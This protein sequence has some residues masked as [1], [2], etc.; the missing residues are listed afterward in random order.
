MGKKKKTIKV[1]LDTNVLL[2]ALLFKG[3]VPGIAR[4]WKK[5]KFTPVIS[6][7]TFKE[8]RSV[9]EYPKFSLSKKEIAVI[10]TR[11]ILPY[12][13]VVEVGTPVKGICKDPDD[14]K[15]LSCAAAASADLIVTG[16]KNLLE[17]KKYGSVRI[18]KVLEL[19]D[20]FHSSS[21]E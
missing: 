4:L 1:V 16:D 8:F 21:S 12:F 13:E 6:G 18:I 17:V 3:R 7:D 14:D 20:L 2:S 9:L 11:E 19:L 5:G 15:F 10:L